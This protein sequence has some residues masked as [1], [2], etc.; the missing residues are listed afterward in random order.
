MFGTSTVAEVFVIPEYIVFLTIHP[1]RLSDGNSSGSLIDHRSLQNAGARFYAALGWLFERLRFYSI[2]RVASHTNDLGAF[3]LTYL[4]QT[5]QIAQRQLASSTLSTSWSYLPNVG[6]RRLAQISNV[7]LSSGQYSTYRYTTTPENL[8][9]AITETSDSP[10]VYPPAGSQTGSYNNLNQL[11]NNSG[12]TLSFDADGNLLSDGLRNYSWDAENRLVG[13]TYSSQSGKA[14]SFSY[15]GRSRRTASASTPAGGGAT[16]TTIYVWCGMHICQ[17]RDASNAPTRGYYTEGEFVAG[18]PAQLYYYAPDQIGSVRRVFASVTSAPAY[19]YDAYGNALQVAEPLADFGYGG[20]FLNSDS[21]LYLTQYRVYDPVIGR[22]LSRDPIGESNDSATNLYAYVWG[23]PTNYW[24]PKGLA[25]IPQSV[26]SA[27]PG[28]P[29]TPAGPGQKPGTFYGPQ[30]PAG[31]RTECR[32]V[33]TEAEG[34]PPGS[35]GYWKTK[36]PGQVGWSRYDSNG[37]PMTPDEAHPGT[38]PAPEP[39]PTAPSPAPET[40]HA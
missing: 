17:A 16:V 37:D 19:T 24:D 12:Q 28:G 15:D 27:I 36:S 21:G 8:S 38:P 11:T 9:R 10:T 7:G 20:F 13:V 6:D 18:P 39:E 4:G 23:S 26:P 32:Y 25:G 34:G 30:Q 31:P 1:F 33:P 3:T 29:Y 40:D 2:S 22:W 5:A 35:Q 14:T